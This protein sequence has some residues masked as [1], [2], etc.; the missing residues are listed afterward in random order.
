MQRPQE[1]ALE[2]YPIHKRKQEILHGGSR[3]EL[4]E[5]PEKT[6]R[7]GIGLGLHHRNENRVDL[8]DNLTVPLKNVLIQIELEQRSPQ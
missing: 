1:Q 7:T 3:G 8:K 2:K 4:L 5:R 6:R